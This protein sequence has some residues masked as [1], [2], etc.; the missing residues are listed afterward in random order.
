MSFFGKLFG[1]SDETVTLNPQESFVAIMLSVIA[2]DGVITDEEASDFYSI[3]NKAKLMQS[4]DE[5]KYKELI[6]KLLRILKKDGPEK[7]IELGLPNLPIEVHQG[8]FAYACDLVFADGSAAKE[9]QD[10]LDKIKTGL[11]ID[12]ALAYKVAEVVMIKNRI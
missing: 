4:V 9:E 12:D 11:N 5:R 7:L 1:G 6:N 3:I 8:T 2:A 10:I